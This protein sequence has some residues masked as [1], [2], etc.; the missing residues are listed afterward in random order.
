MDGQYIRLTGVILDGPTGN[1]GGPGPDG[2]AIVLYMR[3][4]HTELSYSEVRFGQW[5]AGVGGF[6]GGFDYRIIGNYIHDNGGFNGDYTDSQYN[7]SHGIYNS[8]SSLPVSPEW[9]RRDCRG[10]GDSRPVSAPGVSRCPHRA[11]AA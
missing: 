9:L 1:V 7:T 4:S 3:G 5:H 6:E 2:E 8:P 11:G 10:P